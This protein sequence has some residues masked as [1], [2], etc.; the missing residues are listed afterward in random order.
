M[1]KCSTA[2]LSSLRYSAAVPRWISPKAR[3]P[4]QVSMRSSKP[5]PP[6][7]CANTLHGQEL[8]DFGCSCA[9]KILRPHGIFSRPQLSQTQ[10]LAEGLSRRARLLRRATLSLNFVPTGG[11][12]PHLGGSPASSFL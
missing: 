3:L 7:A 6:A 12:Y 8:L 4:Q 5:I 2:L 9:K 11:I 10:T 1:Q